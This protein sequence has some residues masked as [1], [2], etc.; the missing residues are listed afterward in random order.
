MPIIYFSCVYLDIAALNLLSS[1]LFEGT[2]KPTDPALIPP[3]AH[4]AVLATLAI[5]PKHTSRL[6]DYDVHDTAALSLSYLRSV[7][8]TV[9][10]VNA[11][12][13][14]AF[15]YPNL[16]RSGRHTRARNNGNSDSS[17]SSDPE[18][19]GET[20]TE[21]AANE[22]SI[23]TRGQDFWNV[24]G[25]ALNCSAIHPHRWRWW[26]PW[27][28]FMLD[29][30]EADYEERM[31]LDLM[32]ERRGI[33]SSMWRESLLLS[34]IEPKNSR[35]KPL[36]RIMNALFADGNSSSVSLFKEVFSREPKIRSETSK[37]RKRGSVNPEHGNFADYDDQSSTGGSEPP[38]PEH[39]RMTGKDKYLLSWP[40]TALAETVHLRLRVFAL[41][42][43]TWP[44]PL[45]RLYC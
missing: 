21:W 31:R 20:I 13:R 45:M 24:L 12:L 18:S 38:T 15:I 19:D 11:R 35:S 9:G 26:K 17:P 30:L 27:L 37:K 23:W 43:I 28:E 36:P 2:C 14:D 39:Q 25:W 41:V 5:L 22:G 6:L 40:N 7:L 8:A 33:D 1:T 16:I 3:P 44:L 34:Y 42:S 29:V 10:P 32:R 4:L